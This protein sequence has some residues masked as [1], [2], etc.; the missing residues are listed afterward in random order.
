MPLRIKHSLLYITFPHAKTAL[1]LSNM[2]LLVSMKNIIISAF[3]TQSLV[4]KKRF[5]SISH[6][7]LIGTGEHFCKLNAFYAVFNAE[8]KFY[9]SFSE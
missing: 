5:S 4:E 6:Y 3:I 2:K 1:H 7:T 8:D 9:R